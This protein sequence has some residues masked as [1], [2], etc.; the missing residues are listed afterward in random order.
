MLGLELYEDVD[1]EDKAGIIKMLMI[2]ER[3]LKGWWE[4]YKGVP[5][6]LCYVTLLLPSPGINRR[7]PD[8][9]RSSLLQVYSTTFW[10]RS[11]VFIE[12]GM[13]QA[14]NIWS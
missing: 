9:Y 1:N 10:K 2:I 14:G 13:Y 6:P 5:I 4:P 12:T 3:G 8:R 11:I 7:S